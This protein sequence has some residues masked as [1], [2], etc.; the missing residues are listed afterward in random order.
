MATLAKHPE[1][2]RATLLSRHLV[3]RS[4][5]AD[6]RMTEPSVSLRVNRVACVIV[7]MVRFV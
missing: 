1:G 6:L 2:P 7:G 5:L 4:R 3:G